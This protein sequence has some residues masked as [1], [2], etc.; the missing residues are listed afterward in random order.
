MKTRLGSILQL[1]SVFFLA[2]SAV[3]ATTATQRQMYMEVLNEDAEPAVIAQNRSGV[4]YTTTVFMHHFNTVND[5]AQFY[6]SSFNS[7]GETRANALGIPAGSSRVSDPV[8]AQN[9]TTSNGTNRIWLAGVAVDASNTNHTMLAYWTSDNGGFSWSA[10]ETIAVIPDELVD[11]PAI[12]VSA[13]PSSPGY[14]Y[15]AYVAVT[16]MQ[17]QIKIVVSPDGGQSWRGPYSVGTAVDTLDQAPQVMV[18]SKANTADSP[19][20]DVYVLWAHSASQGAIWLAS[21][22]RWTTAWSNAS[23]TV[24]DSL[25]TGPLY[26]RTYPEYMQL[27]ALKVLNLTAPV[28]KLDSARRR[29][30]VAWHERVLGD[31]SLSH[32]MMASY[33]FTAA[34]TTRWS[35]PWSVSQQTTGHPVKPAMDFDPAS[36]NYM[37]T[38]YYFPAGS[39]TYLLYARHTDAFGH[40]LDSETKIG[41]CYTSP[42]GNEVFDIS[43]CTVSVT[44]SACTLGEYHDVSYANGRWYSAAIGFVPCPN[45]TSNADLV[46]SVNPFVWTIQQYPSLL[47]NFAGNGTGAVT[48]SPAGL[49]CSTT[50]TSAF[51]VGTQVTLTATPGAFSSF[52]GWSG[53][54]TGAGSCTLTIDAAKSVTATFAGQVDNPPYAS[55]SVGCTDRTCSTNSQ[56]SSDD[57]GIVNYT[58][59]WGD[60]QTTTGGS[61]ASA[62]SHTY[63]AYGTYTIGLTVRDAANQTSNDSHAV[64]LSQGTTAAFTF[65]CIGRK[66]DLDGSGSASAAALTSYRWDWGDVSAG[67]SPQPFVNHVFTSDG[68]FT[69]DLAVTDAAGRT[70]SVSHPVT[71]SCPYT[72]SPS[73]LAPFASVAATAAI[74]VSTTANCSW[75]VAT[76]VPWITITDN[77]LN[78]GVV[79]FALAANSG[80]LRKGTVTIAGRQVTV[81]QQSTA[82]SFD[83]SG[84]PSILWRDYGSGSNALWVVNGTGYDSVV[85]LP[86][87]PNV[88]YLAETAADFNGDG[89]QDILWRNYSTDADAIWLMNGGATPAVVNLPGNL[90]SNVHFQ[91]A[92]DFNGD[93]KPDIV[94]RNASTGAN[95]VWLMN[96]TSYGSTVNLPDLQNLAYAIAGVADFNGDGHPDLL[97]HNAST[98]LSGIWLMNGTTFLSLVNLPEV[99]SAYHVGAVIDVNGDGSPDIA[100]RNSATGANAIWLLN[101]TAYNQ[102]LISLPPLPGAW[103]LGGPR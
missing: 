35:T 44:H 82:G 11:K 65:A 98:G 14:V 1:A 36:G 64:V 95:Y 77:G 74:Q 29:L 96:G 76:N 69:V 45:T 58:W 4:T 57:R 79:R 73:S 38:Y 56:S 102:S 87:L 10:P 28:A 22:P 48:S 63:A 47:V 54:C 39:P 7:A 59:T 62:P 9:T 31:N 46:C 42:C 34:P 25:A 18:D 52:T 15:I 60:G 50:C 40:S 81:T 21:A 97:W 103:D 85:N 84:R 13:D 17:H 33:S 93:G 37:I 94:L 55:F 5:S 61:S 75:S 86:G 2:A 3:F 78:G 20:G 16:G 101:G 32:L 88:A 99:P 26:G 72:L 89:F 92:A 41:P 90:T 12:A 71:V 100:W 68:T 83:R 23:F 53:A 49:N 51:A 43:G 27:G 8:L 70:A 6:Y 30:S 66:C 80:S 67:T 91:G 24:L 19:T